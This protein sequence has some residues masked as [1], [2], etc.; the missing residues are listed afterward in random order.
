MKHL[1]I[2]LPALLCALGLHCQTVETR[3]SRKDRTIEHLNRRNYDEAIALLESLLQQKPEDDEIKMFLATAYSGSAGVNIIDAFP[4][5]EYL[6][7]NN[8]TK[9]EGDKSASL[10]ATSPEDP[11][12]AQVE[13]LPTDVGETARLKRLVLKFMSDATV[14]LNTLFLIPEIDQT[15]RPLLSEALLLLFQ[16]QPDSDYYLRGNAYGALLNVTVFVAYLREAFPNLADRGR[17]LSLGDFVCSFRPEIFFNNLS[18]AASHLNQAV[19]RLQVV[20]LER[21]GE[22]NQSLLSLEQSTQK[23]VD[24]VTA[25]GGAI[26]ISEAFYRSIK[27]DYCD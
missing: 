8:K 4:L 25:Q 17:G 2:L 5:F 3:V 16:L 7:V 27:I 24:V 6:L 22:V 9:K 18:S 26:F 10:V 20:Q 23:I 15:R 12:P 21:K 14:T 19:T 13:A 1:H 11:E